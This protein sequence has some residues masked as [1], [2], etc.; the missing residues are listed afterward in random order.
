MEYEADEYR[1]MATMKTVRKASEALASLSEQMT[2]AYESRRSDDKTPEEVRE[3]LEALQDLC[4]TSAD[5]L[6]ALTEKLRR[7]AGDEG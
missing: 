3:D 1:L 4:G 2:D 5:V 7:R 6:E